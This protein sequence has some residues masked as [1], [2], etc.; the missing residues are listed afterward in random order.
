MGVG[1]VKDDLKR[2]MNFFLLHK[3]P[4]KLENKWRK[5]F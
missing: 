5:I 3:R 2:K 4:S 1:H